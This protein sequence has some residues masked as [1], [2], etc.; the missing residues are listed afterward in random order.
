MLVVQGSFIVI[1]PYMYT[2]Y[3]D[4]IP[5]QLLFLIP[6]SPFKN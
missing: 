5:P 2:M 6:L 1:F 3:F 4:Q